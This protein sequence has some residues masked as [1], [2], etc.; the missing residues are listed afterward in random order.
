MNLWDEVSVVAEAAQ[1]NHVVISG[2]VFPY[3]VTLQRHDS[4]SVRSVEEKLH[5]GALRLLGVKDD[6]PIGPDVN[7]AVNVMVSSL[8]E[9]RKTK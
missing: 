3:V 4:L 6:M 5:L 1:K 2:G 8:G 7:E 9:E